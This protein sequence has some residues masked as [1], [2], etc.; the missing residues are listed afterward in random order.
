MFVTPPL[1]SVDIDDQNQWTVAEALA[2]Y[3][4]NRASAGLETA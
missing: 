3:D 2:L 4:R 1:E